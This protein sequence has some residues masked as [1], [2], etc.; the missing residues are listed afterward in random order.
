VRGRAGE[1]P[2]AEMTGLISRGGWAVRAIHHQSTRLED[3]FKALTLAD[4]AK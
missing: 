2:F 4:R 1:S 3:V